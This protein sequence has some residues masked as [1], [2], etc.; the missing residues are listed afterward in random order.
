MESYDNETFEINNNEL[1]LLKTY[2]TKTFGDIGYENINLFMNFINNPTNELLTN[3]RLNVDSIEQIV[4]AMEAFINLSCKYAL[5]KGEIGEK[6]Y[7][8][9]DIRNIGGYESGKLTSLKST[10]NK[11]RTAAGTFNYENSVPL[12]FKSGDSFCPYIKIDEIIND[13]SLFANEGEILLPPYINCVLTNEYEKDR[14]NNDSYRVVRIEDSY[15]APNIEKLEDTFHKYGEYKE[16]YTQLFKRDKEQGKVSEELKNATEAI[17]NY[18]KEYARCQYYK[19]NELFKRKYNIVEKNIATDSS[20]QYQG[21][22]DSIN[23]YFTNKD[24]NKSWA[25]DQEY[26]VYA[27]EYLVENNFIP[28]DILSTTYNNQDLGE[29]EK[30]LKERNDNSEYSSISDETYQKFLKLFNIASGYDPEKSTREERINAANILAY[31]DYI[32]EN[33]R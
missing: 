7:R 6:I 4:D 32:E 15:S 12:V 19:Y 8:Y 11:P 30:F 16:T 2:K 1:E 13:A 25:I 27:L 20:N 3:K 14:F 10:S 33:Q 5:N 9:E 28:K 24:P 29:L 22:Y 18:L 26:G 17:N 23:K 21:I 31:G